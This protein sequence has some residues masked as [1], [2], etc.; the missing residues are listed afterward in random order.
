MHLYQQIYVKLSMAASFL[1]STQSATTLW[2]SFKNPTDTVLPGMNISE[3]FSLDI[4]N[5]D[6]EFK[7]DQEEGQ[8]RYLKIPKLL[9]SRLLEK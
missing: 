1:K 6:L 8:L 2:E 4:L 3:F 5:G 9:I 7:Q